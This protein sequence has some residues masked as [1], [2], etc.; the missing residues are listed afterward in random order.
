MRFSVIL[1]V[2]KKSKKKGNYSEETRSGGFI[3]VIPVILFPVCFVSSTFILVIHALITYNTC[4][5]GERGT[6]ICFIKTDYR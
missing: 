1:Y 5:L 6:S 2:Q 4:C 3:A